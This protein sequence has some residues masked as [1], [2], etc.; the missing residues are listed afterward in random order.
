MPIHRKIDLSGTVVNTLFIIKQTRRDKYYDIVYLCKCSCGVEFESTHN[1]LVRKKNPTHSCG[2]KHGLHVDITGKRFGRLIAEKRL[3]STKSGSI[4]LCKCDCG[5]TSN[6]SLHNLNNGTL[7]CG[8]LF[9]SRGDVSNQRFGRL[10]ALEKVE[11]KKGNA[12]WKCKCDCGNYKNIPLSSLRRNKEGA[13][14]CG[15]LRHE[16]CVENGMKLANLHSRCRRDFYLNGVKYRSGYEYIYAEHLTSK[17]IKFL[18]EP[19]RFYLSKFSYTPDFYLP[20][21]DEWVEV[22]GYFLNK[23][24]E[25]VELFEKETCIKLKFIFY[26]DILKI[27]PDYIKWIRSIPIKSNE[28]KTNSSSDPSTQIQVTYFS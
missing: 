14:S 26:E 10:V 11:V 12:I 23:S 5:N 18:Y 6:V 24:K 17:G 8:C 28:S 4:W 25:K 21:T 2:C 1:M 15:C 22:K 27:K 20:E 3:E 19:I 13:K 7:S 9:E 16:L